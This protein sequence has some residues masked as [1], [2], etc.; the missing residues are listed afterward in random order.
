VSFIADTLVGFGAPPPI[1]DDDRLSDLI[2]GDQAFALLEALTSLDATDVGSQYVDHGLD[3]AAEYL[4]VPVDELFAA[5]VER[6]YALPHGLQTQLRRE[7]FDALADTLEEHGTLR[8]SSPAGVVGGRRTSKPL[9]GG[10]RTIASG[11][12]DDLF[13]DEDD[14]DRDEFALEDAFKATLDS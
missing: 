9:A 5:C 10:N 6:N 14:V 1:R 2:N 12:A 8:S 7:Q 4:D 3:L 11:V 13:D